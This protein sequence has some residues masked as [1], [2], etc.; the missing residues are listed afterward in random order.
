MAN[1][2]TISLAGTR[3]K[4]L[5]FKCE[6]NNGGNQ[7]LTYVDNGLNIDVSKLVFAVILYI[8]QNERIDFITRYFYLKKIHRN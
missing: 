8:A 6:R 1:R 4:P 7:V 2:H 3:A 5:W